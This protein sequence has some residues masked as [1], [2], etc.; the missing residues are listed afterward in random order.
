MEDI[1]SDLN[2]IPGLKKRTWERYNQLVKEGK[3]KP[4]P[5]YI[6]GGIGKHDG[7]CSAGKK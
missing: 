1:E 7:Y 5:C 6:C 4:K 2:A 3:I